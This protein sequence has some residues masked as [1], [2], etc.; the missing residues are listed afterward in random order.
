MP[1]IK[2]ED[3]TGCGI[4]AAKCP[5]G[6]ITVSGLGK[7]AIDQLKCVRCAICHEACPSGAVG[8]DSEQVPGLVAFNLD[9]TKKKTALCA[10]FLGDPAAGEQSLDRFIKHFK[11]EKLVAEKTIEQ[12]EKLRRA[13]A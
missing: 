7:A 1:W 4:C 9:D 2:E 8:H 13:S 10:S 3:C 11:R 12:L 6:A 5:A